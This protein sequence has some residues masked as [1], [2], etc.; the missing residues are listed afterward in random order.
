MHVHEIALEEVPDRLPVPRPYDLVTAFG[1]SPERNDA[2]VAGVRKA[3]VVEGPDPNSCV[4]AADG[5]GRVDE[6]VIAR[7]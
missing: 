4:L 2:A 3:G 6:F 7:H 1:Q 5:T